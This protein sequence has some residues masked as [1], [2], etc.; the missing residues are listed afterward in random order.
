MPGMRV[1]ISVGGEGSARL[2]SEMAKEPKGR[3]KFIDSAISF[4]Q[5]HE[6]D[7][8]D[9]HWAYAGKMSAFPGR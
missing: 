7:G 8:L 5:E 2:F 3:K 4:L 9:L 6:F 1:L